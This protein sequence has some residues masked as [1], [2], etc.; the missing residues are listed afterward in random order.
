MSEKTEQ[1][2]DKKLEDAREKGQ[3]PVSR[4]MARLATFFVIGLLSFVTEKLWH[5]SIDSLFEL[6]FLRIG[7]PFLPAML[8]M[9]TAAGKL[10]LVIFG[11]IAI[12][13]TVVAIMAFWG[14][15]GIL[16]SAKALEPKLD[17][18]NPVQGM[19]QLFSKRK[20]VELV[21]SIAK[22]ILIGYVLY[23]VILDQLPT[24]L[25][26]SGGT[27][28]DVYYG[29]VEMLFSIFKIA[30]GICFA[31][32]LVDLVSQRHFHTKSLMMSMDEIK[33]EY[34]ESEGDPLVKGTRKQLAQEW[35]NEEPASRTQDANAVV[36]N[37]THFAVALFYDFDAPSVPMVLAK[38][39]DETAQAMIARA[40]QYNIPVIRHVWLA[41]TLY[42]TAKPD[43][44]IP[45][46]SYESVAHVYAVIQEM[47]DSGDF[48]PLTE[49]EKYGD[50]PGDE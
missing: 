31:F 43:H 6:A 9:V 7:A 18:L 50:A 44:P 21:V 24:I 16:L 2:T 34:K 41:R 25:K 3:V 15:F 33:R 13:G 32:S 30:V 45:K 40:H 17:K 1:P 22:A 38:G 27:P 48:K 8:E 49:L 36:V 29:F 14:Q 39:K 4:D 23:L 28:H 42:A 26:L 11:A 19:M 37:P 35:A 12:T 46:A 5:A 20:L 10:L 47:R